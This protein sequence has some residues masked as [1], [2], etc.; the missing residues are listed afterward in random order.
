MNRWRWT[1]DDE[2]M[3]KCKCSNLRSQLSQWSIGRSRADSLHLSSSKH[4]D[5]LAR[6]P[7][8]DALERESTGFDFGPRFG[9]A[10]PVGAGDRNGRIFLSVFVETQASVWALRPPYAAHH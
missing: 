10:R 9:D 1:D 5:V 2:P 4:E 6:Q 8:D 7:P 3:I